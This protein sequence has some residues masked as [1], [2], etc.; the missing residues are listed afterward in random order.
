[1]HCLICGCSYRNIK[2]YMI[3][4][5][6]YAPGFTIRISTLFECVLKL[7]D[8]R[9]VQEVSKTRFQILCLLAALIHTKCCVIIR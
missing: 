3:I 7:G 5:Y 1:M 9:L 8:Y 4:K 6:R 2:C